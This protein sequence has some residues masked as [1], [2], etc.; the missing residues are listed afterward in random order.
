MARQ[1]KVGES[2]R[3]L[4]SEGRCILAL[5]QF[6]CSLT[7]SGNQSMA[8]DQNRWLLT[9]FQKG[10]P[11]QLLLQLCFKPLFLLENVGG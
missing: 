6:L 9:C 8:I 5:Q 10:F 7:H 11:P 2:R 1:E 4:S 3:F